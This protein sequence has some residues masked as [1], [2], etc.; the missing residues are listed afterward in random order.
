MWCCMR[1]S[2]HPSRYCVSCSFCQNSF[3]HFYQPPCAPEDKFLVEMGE[4][5]PAGVLEQLVNGDHGET[6][7]DAGTGADIEGEDA[8]V[9]CGAPALAISKF[10]LQGF[11]FSETF[12]EKDWR[13]RLCLRVL[14]TPL[15][16]R[17]VNFQ[18]FIPHWLLVCWNNKVA[19][20]IFHKL[21]NSAHFSMKMTSWGDFVLVYN[22]SGEPFVRPD[23]SRTS[24][25]DSDVIRVWNWC[26]HFGGGCPERGL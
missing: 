24:R 23:I 15:D 13:D 2:L 11:I 17:N 3:C 25:I 7:E 16:L 4:E 19:I 18:I 9:V 10:E 22:R 8:D 21:V 26:S 6:Y 5:N 20:H 14:L 1:R 12:R